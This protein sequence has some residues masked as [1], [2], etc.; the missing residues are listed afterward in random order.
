M[1][2]AGLAGA[3]TP[4]RGVRAGVEEALGEAAGGRRLLATARGAAERARG[5]E[6]ELEAARREARDAL[7]E[8]ENRVLQLED[9]RG[10]LQ[11]AQSSAQKAERDFQR[12]R[13]ARVRLQE[14][15]GRAQ[16]AL[17]GRL[18]VLVEGGEAE[19]RAQVAGR[20][21]S[22]QR[23]ALEG[24]LRP[25]LVGLVFRLWHACA[26]CRKK[27]FIYRRTELRSAYLRPLLKAALRSWH[28][29]VESG[30]VHASCL[31]GRAKRIESENETAM[32]KRLLKSKVEQAEKQ[33]QCLKRQVYTSI[34]LQKIHLGVGRLFA[35]WAAHCRLLHSE[36]RR[37]LC[38]CQ[39]K[40]LRKVLRDWLAIADDPR[41]VSLSAHEA[42]IRRCDTDS[43]I[44]AWRLAVARS[45][46]QAAK[47]RALEL[48]TALRTGAAAHAEELKGLAE[49]HGEAL[50]A[51]VCRVQEMEEQ[52]TLA[53][54]AKLDAER[55]LAWT[56]EIVGDREDSSGVMREEMKVP[57]GAGKVA[58]LEEALE[59][60]LA[61][62]DVLSRQ[63]AEWA[64]RSG[65][66]GDGASG[67]RSFEAQ[68]QAADS[69]Y[70]EPAVC[71][72]S[73]GESCLSIQAAGPAGHPLAIVNGLNLLSWSL[74]G[75]RL[76][77]QVESLSS[78][79]HRL[80]LA[81]PAQYL[82]DALACLMSV[83]SWPGRCHSSGAVISDGVADT[84][85]DGT[86]FLERQELEG[87]LRMK[88]DL[89]TE[90]DGLK[91]HLNSSQTVLKSK[92]KECEDLRAELEQTAELLQ[93]EA[94]TRSRVE[95]IERYFGDLTAD[96]KGTWSAYQSEHAPLVSA[97]QEKNTLL[98]EMTRA[99][100][101]QK[102]AMNSSMAEVTAENLHLKAELEALKQAMLASAVATPMVPPGIPTT[103]LDGQ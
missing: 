4:V 27:L 98:A 5:A 16:E 64:S 33:G 44:L 72:I 93:Q 90:R 79:A 31:L 85:A 86:V 97:L 74:D 32:L 3:L 10:Q 84:L 71:V 66:G 89:E 91:K 65:A 28:A 61:E 38:I 101:M 45:Q 12:E 21:L 57:G 41:M 76:V 50:Q 88:S 77:L 56:K 96:L 59:A 15:A 83:Q 22:A 70:F 78:S 81:A 17:R 103:G 49:E 34:R 2:M 25:L 68:F 67:T 75:D 35:L 9:C 62:R 39:R 94:G 30:E 60:L 36:G 43:W 58:Q 80:T 47:K 1:A 48:T 87:I 53:R 102:K 42:W 73:R 69:D 63:A 37:L 18:R 29:L 24:T 23:R 55:E 7:L 19:A 11:L 46:L 14:E 95:N 82:F 8:G 6:R 40:R 54:E 51:Q 13:E 26:M 20:A 52:V 92:R 99:G 100:S